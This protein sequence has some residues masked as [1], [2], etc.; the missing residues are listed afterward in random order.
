[1]PYLLEALY[2]QKTPRAPIWMMRQAGRYLPEYQK[3]RERYKLL[4]MM[5]SAELAA[6]VT[7]QPIERFP[8]DGAIIFAD[9]L[10]PL[11]GMGIDLSFQ[12]K[13]GP[14]IANPIQNHDQIL[15]LKNPSVWE[16]VP[17]TLLAI[18]LVCEGLKDKKVPLLGFSG[19]PFTLSHY[20]LE[21]GSRGSPAPIL[22][23]MRKEG[24]S[25]N[26]LQ[27]KLVDM[28]SQY[29]IAQVEAGAAAVQLFD[30]WV[31]ILSPRDF[32]V[33]VAPYL[34]EIVNKF[35]ARSNAPIIYFGTETTGVLSQLKDLGFNC[36]GL[37]WRVSLKE[38]R[39]LLADDKL[40]LQG[41]LDPTL[42]FAEWGV[43][44][45]NVEHLLREGEVVKPY[46]FNLGHG[47][48]PATPLDNVRRL[49]EMVVNLESTEKVDE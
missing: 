25:Y 19:A 37:D 46:I 41:N 20:L 29:L 4:E 36:I 43:L 9:I 47:I 42:L 8:L 13:T 7:L 32:K 30:S 6:L 10:T 23:L 12:D 33:Y 17:Y 22:S 49:I 24:E 34:I 11:I 5:Q 16:S 45:K 15:A 21:R 35:R 44:S 2:G 26:L 18:K 31:G 27:E 14:H 3:L 1:M 40:T 48:L 38:A 39:S 28:V